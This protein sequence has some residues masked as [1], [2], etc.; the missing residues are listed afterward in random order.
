MP[1]HSVELAHMVLL[2]VT[3]Q[4]AGKL[5]PMTMLSQVEIL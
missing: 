5:G 4:D 2:S 1:S 3:V